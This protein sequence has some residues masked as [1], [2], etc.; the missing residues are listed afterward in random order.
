MFV[1]CIESS[2]QRGLGHLYR[3]LILASGM[4]ERGMFVRFLV[5]DHPFAINLLKNSGYLVDIVDFHVSGWEV[6]WLL[7]HPD[8][9]VWINDRLNTTDYHARRIRDAGLRLVTFDDRGSGAVYADVHVAALIFDHLD[10]L[11]GTTVLQGVAYLLLDPE[12]ERLRHLRESDDRILLTMGGS[13]TWGVTPR[14]MQALRLHG[15]KATIVLGPAFLHHDAVDRVLTESQGDIFTVHRNGVSSLIEQM[16]RHSIAITGG[17]MTPFQAN[18]MGL[19]CI[20]IAN[21][22]FEIPVGK[23]LEESGGNFFAGFHEIMDLS[24]FGSTIPVSLMSKKAMD[25]VDT[26]GLTRV[27]D[28][29]APLLEGVA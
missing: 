27:L 6:N 16:S 28:A 22:P 29:L 11:H 13:D 2:H 12:I 14:V 21:E 17:G 20:V 9:K 23:A 4:R 3:S 19:P 26:G 1:I 25:A 10:S 7:A 8:I 18:A 15:R 5:N 24:I